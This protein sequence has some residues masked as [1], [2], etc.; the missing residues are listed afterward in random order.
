MNK[1]IE[2]KN[3][4]K[5]YRNWTASLKI[6]VI[7]NLNATIGKGEVIVLF[8]PNGSGKSTL[9]RMLAGL[10]RP[11]KGNIMINGIN[12]KKRNR[13]LLLKTG[14]LPETCK[15]HGGNTGIQFLSYIG[16]LLGLKNVKEKALNKMIFFG[17]DKWADVDV[18]IYSE[19]MR[20]RLGLCAATLNDPEILLF[21][22]PLENLDKAM[23]LK[24]IEFIKDYAEKGNT[25]IVATHNQKYFPNCREISFPVFNKEETT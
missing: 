7:E 14:F 4:S 12:T 6:Q 24:L 10:V 25:V 2:I 8:G 17:I 15:F 22:E 9:L 16:K 3:V 20:Q 1:L 19:G 18:S 11:S 21:D 5:N 23:R 13:D